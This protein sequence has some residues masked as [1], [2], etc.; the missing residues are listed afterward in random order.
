[1]NK[2]VF[3]DRDGVINRER[4]DY[5][6]LPEY[7]IINNNIPSAIKLLKQH[8]FLVIVVSNQGGIDK[9]IYTHEQ[10]MDLHNIFI[11]TLEKAATTV[12]AFYYC[13][14]HNTVS[15]CLCRKPEPLMIEKALARFNINPDESVFIGDS[16]RDVQAAEAAGVKGIQ[17]SANKDILPLCK[18]II[19]TY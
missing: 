1:M 4:G 8:G 14:H 13:P 15:K 6:Y 5:S 3:L 19:N 16:L 2:A 10:V 18:Q 7:F 12:D 11:E 9:G 17:I